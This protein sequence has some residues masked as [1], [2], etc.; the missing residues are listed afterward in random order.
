MTID[1]DSDTFRQEY[2][3]RRPTI[4]RLATTVKNALEQLLDQLG[5]D[6]HGVSARV[7]ELGS[8]KEKA[9]RKRYDDPLIEA[10]DLC[11]LRIIAFYPADIDLIDEMI[12]AEFMV[13]EATPAAS[14]TEPDRFGYRSNHYVISVKPGWTAAPAFRDLAGASCC[15]C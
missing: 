8:L 4:E 7:K 2:L 15:N 3:A 1:L 6:V 12:R 13:H 11:G 14:S 10:D 5:I 9:R